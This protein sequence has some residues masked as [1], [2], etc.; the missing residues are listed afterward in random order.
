MSCAA[1]WPPWW[2]PGEAASDRISA[3]IDALLERFAVY[4][5]DSVPGWLPPWA[6]AP[7]AASAPP[8]TGASA[9]P[10]ASAPQLAAAPTADATESASGEPG[11]RR[12]PDAGTAALGAGRLG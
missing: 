4:A 9:P 1:R 3:D 7:P 8:G 6:S 10:G 5:G 2:R 11:P 12:H